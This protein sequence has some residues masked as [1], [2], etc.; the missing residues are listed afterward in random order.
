MPGQQAFVA[1]WLANEALNG[2]P[3]AWCSGNHETPIGIDPS[4]E[5]GW[6]AR[7]R[8]PSVIGDLETKAFTD[9]TGESFLVSSIPFC[10]PCKPGWEN[11][12]EALLTDGWKERSCLGWCPW[13]VLGHEP[14]VHTQV[15]R[16]PTG[17]GGSQ[18]IRDWIEQF[19]PDYF[20][21]G[22]LH[23]APAYGSYRSE[24]GQCQCVNAGR[25]EGATVPSHAIIDTL[26]KRIS[27]FRGSCPL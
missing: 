5:K 20:L 22:H 2:S 11:A 18:Q 16:G 26:D 6:T 27:Y 19:Q 10:H 24:L 17:T 15:A 25:I 13:I 3:I 7:L 9:A 8:H 4:K 21:C 12:V 23:L 1:E 14:P